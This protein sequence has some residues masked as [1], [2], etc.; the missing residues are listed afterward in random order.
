MYICLAPSESRIAL[1]ISENKIR[2]LS[3]EKPKSLCDVLFI[4]EN[5]TY[6][7]GCKKVV[8]AII[9]NYFSCGVVNFVK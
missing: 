7:L 9:V 6:L 8:A 4:V 1:T 3:I 2:P 5:F